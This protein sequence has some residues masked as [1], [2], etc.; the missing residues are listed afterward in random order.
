MPFYR[1]P[2]VLLL[3]SIL[4]LFHSCNDKFSGSLFKS[5][6][7]HQKYEQKLKDGGF[8]NT[9]LYKQWIGAAEASL[10]NPVKIDI[11][12]S[13]DGYFAD[14]NPGAAS[15]IFEALNGEQLRVAL[16][17]QSLD[18]TQLFVDLFKAAD[19]GYKH[20]HLQSTDEGDTRLIYNVS[21]DGKYVLRVQPELL[22]PISFELKIT[23]EASLSNP[24]AKDAN[25]N[26]GS[27]FGDGREA[28]RRKHEGIDIFAARSTPAVAAADGVISRVGTNNLGGKIIS[29]RPQGRSINLYYAHLDTQL[30]TTGET[31]LT[32]DTIGL[33]GNTGN[34]R[35]T[36]PHLHFGIYASGGAVDP[37]P[38]IRPGKS[39]PPRIISDS[40]LRGDTIRIT[41]KQQD[42]AIYTPAVVEAATQNGYR[43]IL[44]DGRKTFLAQNSITSNLR[45]LR[46]LTLDKPGLVYHKPDLSAAIVM[47]LPHRANVTIL[48]EYDQYYLIEHDQ[49]RG[50]ILKN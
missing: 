45:P 10:I 43:V 8:A 29:L 50:W 49:S 33:I 31:V 3:I 24:V 46:T 26:I 13:E 4:T 21:E 47:N 25:Q 30:V 2:Y 11:P 16:V 40:K 27:F 44:P 38:F 7:P 18:S 14:N 28:G 41:S 48:G 22:S 5:Q 42:I 6:T 12:Y 39:Q 23:A 9:A 17:L 34:A 15:F 37:M 19:T 32:G 20:K 1:S 36:P 35:T